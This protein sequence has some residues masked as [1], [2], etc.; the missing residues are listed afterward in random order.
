MSMFG[1]TVFFQR[2]FPFGERQDLTKNGQ[3]DSQFA[4]VQRSP[5]TPGNINDAVYDELQNDV[6]Q[7][8]SGLAEIAWSDLDGGETTVM[9]KDDIRMLEIPK[10]ADVLSVEYAVQWT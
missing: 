1:L 10:Y 4:I 3:Y 9:H 8:D 6:I 7:V 5:T 2:R